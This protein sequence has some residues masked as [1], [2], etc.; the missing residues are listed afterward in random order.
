MSI[1]AIPFITSDNNYRLAVPLDGVNYLF[2]VRWNSRDAAWYISIL[3][4]SEEYIGAGLKLVLGT[5]IGHSNPHPFFR[6]HTLV[7]QDTSGE[8]RDPAYD[9]LGARV[10]LTHTLMSTVGQV[11]GG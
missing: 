5:R 9:D 2:D 7:L 1:E 3:T 6:E 11:D 10:I 4:E 8:D